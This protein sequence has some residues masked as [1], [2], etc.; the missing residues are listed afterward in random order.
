LEI[1]ANWVESRLNQPAAYQIA[2]LFCPNYPSHFAH[3][4]EAPRRC[5][6]GQ[7]YVEEPEKNQAGS[8]MR[9][10]E[11]T[12]AGELEVCTEIL[13]IRAPTRSP[14][15]VTAKVGG[16]ESPYAAF[17]QFGSSGFV[18]NPAG[19]ETETTETGLQSALLSSTEYEK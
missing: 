6:F 19:V 2:D 16:I 10:G 17:L 15:V 13:Q 4:Q 18:G 1:V 3:A 11:S 8:Q 14:Q 12:N 7:T 9:I 5:I